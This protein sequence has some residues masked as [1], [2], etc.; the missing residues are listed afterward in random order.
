MGAEK[1]SRPTKGRLV[2]T[3]GT[4]K[5]GF[6]NHRLMEELIASGDASYIG[7]YKTSEKYPLVCG[8]YRVPFLLNFPGKG[9]YVYGEVYRVTDKGLARLDELEG[10]S[11]GHYQRLPLKIDASS[12]NFDDNESVSCDVQAYYAHPSYA[13]QMWERNGEVG[14]GCYTHKE[15]KGY[16]KRQDRPQHMSFL[17][18]ISV[19]LNSSSC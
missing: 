16:V 8:P 13:H 2:F 17:D 9:D 12:I 3:Y 19:F 10:T 4:L 11:R 18:H 1:E 14:F 6:S 5:K 7:A 15:A